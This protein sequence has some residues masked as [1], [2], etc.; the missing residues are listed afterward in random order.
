MNKILVILSIFFS[1]LSVP[2]YG[3]HL[4]QLDFSLK[5]DWSN[6]LQEQTQFSPGPYAIEYSNAD[7]KLVIGLLRNDPKETETQEKMIKKIQDLHPDITLKQSQIQP[8]VTETMAHLKPYGYSLLDL[9]YYQTIEILNQHYGPRMTNQNELI[10]NAKILITKINQNS[11]FESAKP[12]TLENFEKW[13]QTKTGLTFTVQNVQNGDLV[14]PMGVKGTTYL[15]AFSSRMDEVQ[16]NH[17]LQKLTHVL[18]SKEYKTIV[19]LRA[20]SKFATEGRIL[21]KM[22]GCEP[23]ILFKS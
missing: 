11:D 3:Q 15:Q 6:E 4:Y 21:T 8:S 13:F 14:A 20:H 2:A 17:F 16:D 18:N 23:K 1:T 10:A 12:L 22:M 19:V 5:Q 9:A 7:K